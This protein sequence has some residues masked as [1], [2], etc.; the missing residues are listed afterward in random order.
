M[1]V[2]PA[3]SFGRGCQTVSN[4]P[5]IAGPGVN[6]IIASATTSTGA[7]ETALS[8]LQHQRIR[9]PSSHTLITTRS[10][11]HLRIPNL[12]ERVRQITATKHEMQQWHSWYL[13]RPCSN[14]WT[15]GT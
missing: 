3:G 10:G 12:S 5:A 13:G 8:A 9:T 1:R 11:G 2:R 6:N 14:Q 15:E 7:T 4:W